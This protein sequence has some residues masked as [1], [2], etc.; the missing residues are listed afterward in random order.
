MSISKSKVDV[1]DDK[2]ISVSSLVEEGSKALARMEPELAQ[3]FFERAL[4]L[5]PNNTN[6]M[7]ALAD[8]FIQVGEPD[9]AVELLKNSTKLAPNLNPYKW[10][11]LAQLHCGKDSANLYRQAINVLEEYTKDK[12]QD[13]ASLIKKQVVRA[14]CSIADLYL[15]DL[16]FEEDAE[17]QCEDAVNKALTL[18]SMSL[19][20]KQ[21]KA[22]LRLS[23][24]RQKEAASIIAEVYEQVIN[25]RNKRQ[26]RA[27][28]EEF[29]EIQED[30]QDS[31]EV[32]LEELELEFCVSTVKLL[33]ECS[34]EDNALVSKAL[35]LAVSLLND[36]DEQIEIWYLIG[37]ASMTGTGDHIDKESARYHLQHAKEMLEKLQEQVKEDPFILGD[38]YEL[39]LEHLSMLDNDS[40]AT[41]DCGQSDQEM[42]VDEEW[43]DEEN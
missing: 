30:Q 32:E 31:E 12:G 7:D 29:D 3:K 16:C 21:T 14:Y 28:I 27:V 19:D 43:S 17:T 15:T 10:L 22:S 6:L 11:F 25:Q 4:S 8:I 40:H 20:G 41:A 42:V 1:K 39:V 35:E 37:V 5:E 24:N 34:G 23:Q 13:E 9:K 26:S 2:I 33:I 18:D 36:D 38:R